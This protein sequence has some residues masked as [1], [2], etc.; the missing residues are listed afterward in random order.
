ML[1]HTWLVLFQVQRD[2]GGTS[3]II[4]WVQPDIH[5]QAKENQHCDY[6][7]YSQHE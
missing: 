5:L 1:S 6:E 2:R 7:T 3:G 4:D